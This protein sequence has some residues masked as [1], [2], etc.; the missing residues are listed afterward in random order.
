MQQAPG[1]AED[2]RF[3]DAVAAGWTIDGPITTEEGGLR[4]VLGHPVTSAAEATN[5]LN[6]LGPPFSQ[7]ALGREVSEDGDTTTTI[8]TGNLVLTGGF[9]AFAD[10]DLVAAVGGSPYADELAASGATPTENM[11]VTFRAALP[12]EVDERSNGTDVEGAR[13]WAAPLDG[14][15]SAVQL[16]TVQRPA[17]GGFSSLLATVL[18]ILFVLWMAAATAFVVSVIRARARKAQRRRRALARLR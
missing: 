10:A 11:A 16:Q 17:G 8:L 2:L 14:S 9:D 7:M 3:D 5:L 18:L 15:T 12:G 1:L 13:Q 6:S 4:V